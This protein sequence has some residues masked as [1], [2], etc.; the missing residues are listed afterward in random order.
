MLFLQHFFNTINLVNGIEKLNEYNLVYKKPTKKRAELPDIIRCIALKKNSER[1]NG[2]KNSGEKLC[3]IHISKGV[4]Y[5]TVKEDCFDVQVQ[6]SEKEQAF[7]QEPKQVSEF[8]DDLDKL[9]FDMSIQDPN[10]TEI[11]DIPYNYNHNQTDNKFFLPEEFFK[12]LEPNTVENA[13]KFK[14]MIDKLLDE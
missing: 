3:G 7:E 13:Q 2:R 12:P 11:A 9:F 8:S 4:H 5:G 6:V 1:C 10:Y 14:E